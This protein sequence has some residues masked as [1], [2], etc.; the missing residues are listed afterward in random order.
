MYSQF[1]YKTPHTHTS[2]Q[3]CLSASIFSFQGD[4]TENSSFDSKGLE[5][6]SKTDS[7]SVLRLLIILQIKTAFLQLFYY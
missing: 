6:L 2:Q 1:T 3:L 7:F 5:L 4:N